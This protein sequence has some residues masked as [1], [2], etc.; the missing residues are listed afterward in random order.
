MPH[1]RRHAKDPDIVVGI[2][3]S[4]YKTNFISQ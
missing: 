1:V 4:Q 2:V 3:K